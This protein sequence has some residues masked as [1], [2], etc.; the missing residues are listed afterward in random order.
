MAPTCMAATAPA[1]NEPRNEHDD[2]AVP[3]AWAR[4][5]RLT[6]TVAPTKKPAP[7]PEVASETSLVT[8]HT[9]SRVRESCKSVL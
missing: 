6:V 2:I 1:I 4:E 7:M 9:V 8:R 5:R 3:G